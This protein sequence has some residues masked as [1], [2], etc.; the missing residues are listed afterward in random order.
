MEASEAAAGIKRSLVEVCKSMIVYVLLHCSALTQLFTVACMLAGLLVCLYQ[1]TDGN[2][3][4]IQETS[5]LLL[6]NK[7]QPP[8]DVNKVV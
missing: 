4:H 3:A 7:S 8:V 1:V 5:A 2:G 6:L